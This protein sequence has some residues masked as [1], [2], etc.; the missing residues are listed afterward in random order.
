MFILTTPEGANITSGPAE[1]NFPLLL[2]FNSSNFPFNQAAADGRDIR[3]TTVTGTAL[4]YQIEQWDAANGR[5]AVWVK[6]PSIAANARQEIKM[7]WG[8]TG[9][10]SESRGTSVFNASN[11][12]VRVHAPEWKCSGF[13]RL[14]LASQWRNHRH[15]RR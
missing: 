14:D 6:I 4:S 9:V 10:T 7:Y 12:Y 3:F 1:T 2:R 5:A 8:K 15:Q 11:G 13:N